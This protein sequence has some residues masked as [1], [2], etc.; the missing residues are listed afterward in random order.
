MR[1]HQAPL[2][3]HLASWLVIQVALELLYI[4]FTR[5]EQT[6]LPAR[7]FKVRSRN[8]YDFTR[9]LVGF[10]QDYTRKLRLPKLSTLIQGTGRMA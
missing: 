3:S 9:T 7:V 2:A 5:K 8:Y 6:S 10:Y 4:K 1:P